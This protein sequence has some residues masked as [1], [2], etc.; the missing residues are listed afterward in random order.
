VNVDLLWPVRISDQEFH[1][2]ICADD[3]A[4]AEGALGRQVVCG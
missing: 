2:V 1:A 4:A 3:A